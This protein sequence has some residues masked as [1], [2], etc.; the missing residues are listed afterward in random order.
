MN[1]ALA[2]HRARTRVQTLLG[3]DLTWLC[4]F[5]RGPKAACT[6]VTEAEW[7]RVQPYAW[8][9]I[10]VCHRCQDAP[11]T[12]DADPRQLPLGF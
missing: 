12:E 5:G 1:I 6:S 11:S 7:A 8:P 4:A 3:R 9:G 10:T 2:S